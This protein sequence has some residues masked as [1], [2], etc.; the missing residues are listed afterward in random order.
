M[1]LIV[2]NSVYTAW[3]VKVAL[4]LSLL[5]SVKPDLVLALDVSELRVRESDNAE[6]FVRA[7]TPATVAYLLRKGII[8]TLSDSSV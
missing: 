3:S 6:A 4:G 7:T 2:R 5:V 1:V 8:W